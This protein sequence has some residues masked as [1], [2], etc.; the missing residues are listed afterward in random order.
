M[1]CTK[2]NADK[3]TSEFHKQREGHFP[4][5]KSCRKEYDRK[6]Q[7]KRWESGKKK[8]EIAARQ[9]RNREYIWKH[10][11]ES[12]CVDCG[13]DDIVVLQFDHLRDKKYNV[14]E[15]VAQVAS[16]DLIQEE[17]DKCEVVCTN[18]HLRRTAKQQAWRIADTTGT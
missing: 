7:R 6:Y 5:C 17:I 16:L 15:M 11:S 3:P 2:C 12:P 14:S 9:Q 18:C 8:A 10:L 4:W 13:E 1:I